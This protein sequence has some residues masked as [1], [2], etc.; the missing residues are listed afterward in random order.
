VSAIRAMRP[1]GTRQCGHTLQK[2]LD[3][4][5]FAHA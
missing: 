3:Q 2:S 4:R 5:L 1:G